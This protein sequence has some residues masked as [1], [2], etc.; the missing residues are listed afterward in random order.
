MVS[1]NIFFTM[2]SF[3]VSGSTPAQIFYP[4]YIALLLIYLCC[5]FVT[6]CCF[7]Y[8]GLLLIHLSTDL[9]LHQVTVGGEAQIWGSDCHYAFSGKKNSMLFLVPKLFPTQKI[10]GHVFFGSKTLLTQKKIG[11]QI[12]WHNFHGTKKQLSLNSNMKIEHILLYDS[13]PKNT[14]L[15]PYTLPGLPKMSILPYEIIK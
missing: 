3:F 7:C 2:F 13:F 11:T 12:C 15:P 5:A 9:A 8:I 6:L 1:D 4:S 14:W 10:Q